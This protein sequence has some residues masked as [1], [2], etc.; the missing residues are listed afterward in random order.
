MTCQTCDDKG[1]TLE[2]C[3]NCKGHGEVKI[4]CDCEE[5]RGDV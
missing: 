5:G 1:Y 2:I 4:K 3:G